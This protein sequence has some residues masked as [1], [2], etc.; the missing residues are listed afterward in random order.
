MFSDGIG[1]RPCSGVY[2]VGTALST[3]VGSLT[4]RHC[5]IYM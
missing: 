1:M 2:A 3:V 5:V 4:S